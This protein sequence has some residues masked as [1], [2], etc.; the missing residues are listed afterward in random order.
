MVRDIFRRYVELRSVHALAEELER[1]GVVSRRR[2]SAAGNVTGGVPFSRGALFHL[3]RNR[4]Y[5]GDIVHRGKPYPGLHAAIVDADLFEAA[6]QQLAVNRLVRK[7]GINGDRSPLCGLL[8]DHAGSPMSPT[9]SRGKTGDRY[10]YYVSTQLQRGLKPKGRTADELLR[11]PAEPVEQLVLDRLRRLAGQATASWS[12]LV[13]ALKRVEIRPQTVTLVVRPPAGIAVSDRLAADDTVEAVDDDHLRL[14]APVRLKARGGK[15]WLLSPSAG[16]AVA[17][18]YPDRSLIQALRK[19]HELVASHGLL[20]ESRGGD[21]PD[22]R[23]LTDPYLRRV[24]RLAFLAPDIQQ[25]ILD[26]AQPS[27]LKLKQI[28]LRPIPFCWE[29]QRR[30]FGFDTRA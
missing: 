1:R 29:D 7:V 28:I 10:R 12:E 13:P 27:G 21:M 14:V 15:T 25:A 8:F 26:G 19:A 6:Q 3:L 20:P 2:T 11:I 9:H 5:L 17:G 30:A 23:T 18:S 24:L 16:K 4:I 22:V